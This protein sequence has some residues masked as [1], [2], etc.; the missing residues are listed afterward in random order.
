MGIISE[1]DVLNS[2]GADDDWERPISEVMKKDVVAYEVET[3][4]VVIWEFL[5]R[6]TL[7]RVVIVNNDVPIGVISRGTLLRW[8][9]N[10]VALS[11]K[12]RIL[13]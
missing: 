7:R 5:Q 1:K 4:V 8:L 9:G 3:P 2:V 10:W 11:A 12:Y 6:V 13:R